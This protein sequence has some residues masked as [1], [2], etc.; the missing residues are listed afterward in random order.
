MQYESTTFIPRTTHRKQLETRLEAGTRL[1]TIT[2]PPGVGK[3]R[4]IREFIVREEIGQRFD[5]ISFDMCSETT[6]AELE[7]RLTGA[8]QRKK[9]EGS[10]HRRLV[11][12]DNCDVILEQL[13]TLL[14]DWLETQ[15]DT[16]F[17]LT[18][19]ES[20]GL[21]R[22]V[23]LAIDPLSPE[24]ARSLYAEVAHNTC[25]DFE[26]RAPVESVVDNL[27]SRLDGLPLAVELAARRVP[28]F[29]PGALLDRLDDRLDL[30]ALHADGSPNHHHSLRKT[31]Q[32]S[33]ER[34]DEM[35]RKVL[36][37][38]SVFRSGFDI[39]AAESIVETTSGEVIDVIDSLIRK[40]LLSGTMLDHPAGENRL[41]MLESIRLFAHECLCEE[42]S[43]FE[44]ARYRH[45]RYYAQCREVSEPL[46][47]EHSDDESQ[48]FQRL[49]WLVRERENLVQASNYFRDSDDFVPATNLAV[50]LGE[51]AELH[52]PLESLEARLTELIDR[53]R[54]EQFSHHTAQLYA[55]RGEF[56]KRNGRLSRACEDWGMG[57]QCATAAGDEAMAIWLLCR[58]AEGFRLQS[59]AEDAHRQI[60]EALQR[61]DDLGDPR[62]R[63]IAL[64]CRAMCYVDEGAT[65]EARTALAQLGSLPPHTDVLK[66]F[67]CLRI[68]IGVRF[69]LRDDAELALLNGELADLV[70]S[71]GTTRLRAAY[72][73]LLGDSAYSRRELETAIEAYEQSL[74]IFERLGEDYLSSVIMSSLGGICMLRGDSE[75][76][77][78]WFTRA[79]HYCRT[80][81]LQ[82]LAG[83]LMLSIAALN[84]ER[85]QH[86]VAENYYAKKQQLDSDDVTTVLY[87]SW[88]AHL[89]GWNAIERG[90]PRAIE[91]IEQSIEIDE[92][93]QSP[94]SPRALK[95][96]LIAL[97][98]AQHRF[99]E[100]EK[101]I[102]TM[103]RANQSTDQQTGAYST[104]FADLLTLIWQGIHAPDRHP[105]HRQ[106]ARDYLDSLYDESQSG[107]SE[108]DRSPLQSSTPMRVLVAWVERSLQRLDDEQPS[109]EAIAKP[110]D[111]EVGLQTNWFRTAGEIAVD[112]TRRKAL[113]LVLDALVDHHEEHPGQRVSIETLF[114]IGWPGESIKYES[115]KTRVYWAIYTLRKLGIGEALQTGG[116]G[117]MLDPRLIIRRVATPKPIDTSKES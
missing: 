72:L 5:I 42:A 41:Q 13:S 102:A 84:H 15:P 59:N 113:R 44:Q 64:A 67:K 86:D 108:I 27:I 93:L 29:P 69:H 77:A 49:H 6:V 82:K 78:Q 83:Q 110:A 66:E 103:E 75:D 107:N 96:P 71:V 14:P 109:A 39:A 112:L 31:L 46:P 104:I 30:L 9:G 89:R 114:D 58:L 94:Q 79:L 20:L 8:S 91:F 54:P 1:L 24:S 2:G 115:A 48:P 74:Q 17:V 106:R 98:I 45:A 51:I 7:S 111:L 116:D 95:S 52:G 88:T 76:A 65:R 36:A 81:G 32:W 55:T 73:R 61:I 87:R 117:Y 40:S 35:E 16:F 63:R 37:Q 47:A 10:P 101:A 68:L 22:E 57:L 34:L 100:R 80:M 62:L 18:T 90:Q 4:F 3:S 23:R 70:D 50:V 92:R 53:S 11:V 43:T 19:R 85:G 60:D 25:S 33:W 12:I 21:R 97:A 26:L 105:D 99:D 28:T 38:C 56:H